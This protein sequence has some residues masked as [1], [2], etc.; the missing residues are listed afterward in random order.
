MNSDKA[1]RSADELRAHDW[2]LKHAPRETAADYFEHTS[3]WERG[4]VANFRTV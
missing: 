2:V 4:L 1:D 3:F